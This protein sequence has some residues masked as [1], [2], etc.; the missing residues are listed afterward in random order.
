MTQVIARTAPPPTASRPAANPPRRPRRRRLVLSAVLVAFAG[1]WVVPIWGLL[2]TSFRSQGDATRTGWWTALTDPWAQ[3]WTLDN[4]SDAF[5]SLDLGNNFLNSVAVAVPATLL[6]ILFAAYAAYGFTFL[7]F[8]GRESLF[9]VVVG[10]LVVPIQIALIPI[11][12]AFISVQNTTGVRIV[13]TYPAAWMVHAT[14]ALPLAIYIL[15]NYM[16][17]LPK[18]LIEAALV[19]GASHHQIFWRVVMPLS[20]PA[21]ASFAIFQFMWVWNDYLIAYIFIGDN[22][23]VLTQAL[24]DLLGQYSQGWQGVAAGS[25]ITMA[26]PL[27][28]FFAL[29]RFFVQGLTAGAVK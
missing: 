16:S 24:F 25:F 4:F 13:G 20:V 10:L 12:Q 27:M 23:P 19:D 9:A 6:P 26:V 22:S 17:T 21:V 29:Q 2:V 14:F 8:R 3:Q 28:V 7:D 11:L 15:R 18:A 5:G 1:L